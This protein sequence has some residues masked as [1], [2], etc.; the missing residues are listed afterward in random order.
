[1]LKNTFSNYEVATRQLQKM[2]TT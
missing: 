1:L 2:Y